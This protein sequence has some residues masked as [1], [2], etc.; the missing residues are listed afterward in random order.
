MRKNSTVSI[1][2]ELLRLELATDFLVRSWI[3]FLVYLPHISII[4]PLMHNVSARKKNE[5]IIDRTRFVTDRIW[6]F[7]N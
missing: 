6:R 3:P 7:R 5:N 2:H 1:P 4:R